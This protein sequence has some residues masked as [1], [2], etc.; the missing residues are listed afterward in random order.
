M[1]VENV[2]HVECNF[3]YPFFS[4]VS[5]FVLL[6]NG[7]SFGQRTGSALKAA[8]MTCLKAAVMALATS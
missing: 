4:G 6:C 7:P 2:T 3:S 1:Q 5:L 8:I